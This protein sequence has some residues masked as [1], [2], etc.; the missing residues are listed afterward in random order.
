MGSFLQRIREAWSPGSPL[1]LPL[2]VGAMALGI[3]LAFLVVSRWP[4]FGQCSNGAPDWAASQC[5]SAPRDPSDPYDQMFG[6][7][8]SYVMDLGFLVTTAMVALAAWFV[9]IAAVLAVRM[10]EQTSGGG[11]TRAEGRSSPAGWPD[12]KRAETAKPIDPTQVTVPGV[13]RGET[14]QPSIQ[15]S[16]LIRRWY[17]V[18]AVVVGYL[19]WEWY[20]PMHPGAAIA[21]GFAVCWTIDSVLRRFRQTD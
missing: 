16:W 5:A 19:I 2:I 7:G 15:T 3:A 14:A 11:G 8:G 17:Y 12:L 6:T 20:G 13:E 4:F 21:I 18:G 1:R 9:I 10:L